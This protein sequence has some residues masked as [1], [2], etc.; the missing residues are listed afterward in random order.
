MMGFSGSL[1]NELAR[2]L[3]R[4][5]EVES[6][7]ARE[8]R[9][10]SGARWKIGLLK[11]GKADAEKRASAAVLDAERRQRLLDHEMEENERLRNDLLRLEQRRGREM[12]T[13][14][15]EISKWSER[16]QTLEDKL[17]NAYRILNGEPKDYYFWL[18]SKG[19]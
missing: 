19:E 13:S 7:L 18:G 4:V 10:H 5:A 9:L 3:A 8:R 14:N 15:Q 11:N 6:E 1:K 16:A 17:A 12:R 2:A